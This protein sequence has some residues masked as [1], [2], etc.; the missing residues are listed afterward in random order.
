MPIRILDILCRR[1][2]RR[3]ELSRILRRGRRRFSGD[4][5]FDLRSVEQGLAPG[6]TDTADDSVLLQRICNAWSRAMERQPSVPEAF[7]AHEWWRAVGQRN[8]GV[9][10]RAL[11][12]YDFDVLRRI[13]RNFFRNESSTGLAGLPLGQMKSGTPA[14]KAFKQLCLIDGLH[15]VDL[16]KSKTAGRFGLSDLDPPK[17]GN[18]FGIVIDDVFVRNGSEDQNYCAHRI[19]DLLASANS[20]VVAE[21]GGGFGG[22]A[23]F[24]IRD[25]PGLTYVDFDVPETIALASYYLLSAFPETKATLY[26]EAELC[27]ETLQSSQIIL[28][29]AFAI[30]DLPACS[31]D[32]AFNARVLSDL[33]TP[34]LHRYLAE[35][36]RTTHGYLFHLNRK[37]GSN[38]A[39]DWLKV[40][41]PSFQLVERRRSE[42]N[43]ART[44]RPNE[45]EYLYKRLSQVQ[46]PS[47]PGRP[48]S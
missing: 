21:I 44:L 19:V 42:W 36:V 5:L 26:G 46:W 23:Y 37:E 32:V 29:P 45:M 4:A 8:L 14:S 1:L 3:A 30:P 12:E 18:P 9:I 39:D 47:E 25:C 16:W 28:M 33:S 2:R 40:N 22:M 41:A 17:I 24:L 35:I 20:P 13:Y 10:T 43:D 27:A 48:T 15:R 34:S 6:K 7:Q 11:A 31:V 38:A